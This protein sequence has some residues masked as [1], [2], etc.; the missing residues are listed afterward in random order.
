MAVLLRGVAFV[1]TKDRAQLLVVMWEQG[2]PAHEIGEAV[3]A[4][5]SAIYG[6]VQRLQLPARRGVRQPC[7]SF[8][9]RRNFLIQKA[10]ELLAA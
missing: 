7:R 8:Y 4:T 10:R 6:K 9:Q 5:K 1:W 2:Y 3:G